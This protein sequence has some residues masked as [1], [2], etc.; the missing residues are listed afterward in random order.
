MTL[1]V[2][3]I[4]FCIFSYLKGVKTCFGGF[5]K[6]I[7]NLDDEKYQ[8]PYFHNS[9]KRDRIAENTP[10]IMICMFNLQCLS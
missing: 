6:A 9:I 7:P 8:L 5:F 4:F 10:Y 1:E 3:G 2:L